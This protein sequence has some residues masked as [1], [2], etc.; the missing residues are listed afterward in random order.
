[1]GFLVLTGWPVGVPCVKGPR[2]VLLKTREGGGRMRCMYV[3]RI[4]MCAV[5][6]NV[7][8]VCVREAGVGR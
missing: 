4:V 8:R 5:V 7:L 1:M 2:V 3:V 6:V